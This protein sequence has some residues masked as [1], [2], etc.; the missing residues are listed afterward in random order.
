MSDLIQRIID[1]VGLEGETKDYIIIDT[2]N[3]GE[4][5]IHRNYASD[6]QRGVSVCVCEWTTTAAQ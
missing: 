4:S 3:E 6:A 2:A 5:L 1:Q